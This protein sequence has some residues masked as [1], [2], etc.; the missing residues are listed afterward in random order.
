MAA[1]NSLTI[2]IM[3]D[4]HKSYIAKYLREKCLSEVKKSPLNTIGNHASCLIYFNNA[5]IPDLDH[6]KD[7][8]TIV[9]SILLKSN[10][11]FG[12]A[13]PFRYLDLL[14]I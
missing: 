12:S 11:D 5:M 9:N 2:E 10:T 3:P 13:W 4:S 6:R 7:P 1:K 8:E 14:I